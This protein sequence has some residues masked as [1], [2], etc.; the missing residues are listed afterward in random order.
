M[1][2]K[3]TTQ[4]DNNTRTSVAAARGSKSRV[5]NQKALNDAITMETLETRQ[6][7]TVISV[8]N[9]GANTSGTADDSAAI[10]SALNAAKPGDTV[11][12]PAGTYLIDN[13]LNVPT[14]ITIT[15]TSAGTSHLKF[16]LAGGDGA[17]YGISLNGNDS[18]VT[19]ENLD[20][21]S[22]HGLISMGSGSEYQNIVITNNRFEYGGGQYSNGT[23]V[24]GLSGGV[25]NNGTQITH[26]YFHDSPQAA[27]NWCF[28]FSENSNFDYNTFYNVNDG[29]QLADIGPNVSFSYNYGTYL[30]RMGQE[31]DGNPGSTLRVIGNTFYDYV[32]PYYDTEGVSVVEF[33]NGAQ[34]EDNYF[35]AN[36]APGSGWGQADP[37]GTHRFGYAIEATGEPG[38]VSGNT[39]I[40]TWAEVVSSMTTDVSIT[41]NK[42]Y[43]SGLW[44]DFEG[45]PGPY[46]EGSANASNNAVDTNIGDAP[47]APANTNSYL[48]TSGAPVTVTPTPVTTT[49]T[50][51]T[52]TPT[53][54]TVAPTPTPVAPSTPVVTPNGVSG[55]VVTVISDTSVKLTWTNTSTLTDAAVSII[56]TMGRQS[57]GS[58]SLT[59]NSTSATITGLH[60]GWQLDFEITGKTSSGAAVNSAVS[61]VQM[62]GNSATSAGTPTLVAPPTGTVPTAPVQTAPT[63]GSGITGLTATVLGD[64]SVKLSWTT[65]ATL[66]S[67]QVSIITTIGRQVFTPLTVSG[68][69]SSITIGNLHAGWQ[70]DF[71]VTGIASDGTT[72]T[73]GTA[74]VQTTGNSQN[75]IAGNPTTLTS[76][77]VTPPAVAIT[78]VPAATVDNVVATV[79]SDTSVQLTWADTGIDQ[80]SA[81][82]GVITT[83][84]RQVYPTISV[85][86]NTATAT[87]TGLHAGWQFDFTV[88]VAN[89][90]GQTVTS[91]PVT[92]LTTGSSTTASS[93]PMSIAANS[94]LLAA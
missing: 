57:F 5:R 49:P 12:F 84:G 4:I 72:V 90:A 27:R 59:D 1:T 93:A 66:T 24:Y 47:A 41:N 2:K 10:Q 89:S 82:I 6:L 68:N 54:V 69:V 43:G 73:S 40:G 37:G 33:I 70:F 86:G 42:V 50:P 7:M 75:A 28:F 64:N 77:L 45:E 35:D 56:S 26:N 74:T 19:I 34:I 14:G 71:A 63:G 32:D 55:L 8:T 9:Y 76:A 23:L 62:T 29:G 13:V 48:G 16:N 11:S 20:M 3:T 51:V 25:S 38:T 81:Q 87:I 83:I 22:N 17:M 80:A 91:D 65:T 61:T 18:N 92:V 53:P 30:H 88:M 31:I 78:E 67:T 39:L 15:G 36:I 58:V 79:L 94:S 52:T 85:N 21:V 44:G 60:A 46:G